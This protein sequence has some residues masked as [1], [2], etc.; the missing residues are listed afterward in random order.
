MAIFEDML[1]KL[2]KQDGESVFEARSALMTKHGFDQRALEDESFLLQETGRLG[3]RTLRVYKL[4]DVVEVK[5]EGKI[6]CSI[7]HI[8]DEKND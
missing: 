3:E 6:R 1:T 4:I 8:L 2:Q 7:E 5:I